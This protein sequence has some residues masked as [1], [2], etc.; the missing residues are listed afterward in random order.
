MLPTRSALACRLRD[1]LLPALLML[2]AWPGPA[3]AQDW[4]QWGGAA[5]RN[6]ASAQHGLPAWFK[7]GVK[8]SDGAG[9]DM[10]TTANVKWVV[11]L[12]SEALGNASVSG[13]K[14][15]LGTNDYALGDPKYQETGGGAVRCF[16]EA[17]GQLLWRLVVPRIAIDR[18]DRKFDHMGLGICS[19]PTVDGDRVY[20][21]TNRC[22]VV[23]LDANGMADGNQGPVYDEGQYSVGAERP[24][25][26]PGWYDADILWRYDMMAELGVWPHDAANS[27]VLVFGDMLYVGTS[28]GVDRSKLHKAISP[29]APSL[30]ALDKHTGRL[31][32]QDGEQIGVRVFHGQW[33]SPSLGMVNG[34]PLIL[35]GGGDGLCYAFAPVEQVYDRPVLLNKVWSFDCNPPGHKFRDGRPIDYW[36]GDARFSSANRNDGEYRG[37]S[38]II[39]TPVC[40]NNRVYVAVGQDPLH[41]RGRGALHCIDATQQGDISATGKIWSFEGLDRSMSTVS[42]ADGLLYLA[43]FTGAIHCLDAETGRHHWTHQT[44]SETWGS[45]LVADGKVYLGT[46]KSFW[47]LAAGREKRVLGSIRLGA[48]SW[49]T[50]VVANGVLFVSS[51]RYLWALKAGEPGQRLVEQV[52]PRSR[53]PRSE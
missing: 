49:T 42:I 25:V 9:I 2:A 21:V 30:I 45:T 43:D 17:S 7:P 16:D 6:M 34:R 41:G 44:R 38:E 19:S 46:K 24:P 5:Q 10:A 51:D 4:P 14:V 12:G 15:F 47:I 31:V 39:A 22:E 29:L 3:P 37:P 8:R 36:S 1:L 33:S 13:G 23:C 26:Q 52:S 53:I 35:F 50:P 18:E 28:N 48:P 20:V 11:R 27:S 40:H 32:A